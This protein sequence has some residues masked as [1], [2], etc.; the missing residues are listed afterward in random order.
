MAVNLYQGADPSLVT[1]AARAGFATA[2]QSYARTFED[3]AKSYA[4]T[5]EATSGMWKSIFDAGAKIGVAIDKSNRLEAQKL[6]TIEDVMGTEGAKNVFA[7]LEGFKEEMKGLTG[8]FKDVRETIID[9]GGNEI[10]NRN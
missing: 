8:I 5:M 1:A 10:D 7:K 6:Q 2:P 9:E 4:K 3:V